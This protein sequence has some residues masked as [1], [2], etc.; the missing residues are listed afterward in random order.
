[1][2][3]WILAGAAAVALIGA[4][5]Y[6]QGARSLAEDAAAFGAREAVSAARLSPDGSRVLYVTPGPGLKS[7]AVISDLQTGKSSV[8]TSASG[9]PETLDW[10]NY[11][12]PA[13]LVCRISGQVMQTGDIV[14]FQ[15]LL[16]MNIDGTDA[17]LLGQPSSFYDASL[18][19]FDGSVLD[20]NG[21][22][23]GA[24][25]MERDYVPEAG[26][27]Q[28]RISRT[29]SGLGVDRID[30]RTLRVVQVEPA[31]DAASG[32]MTDGRGNIRVMTT[33]ETNSQGGLT[34]RVKYFYRTTDSREWKTLAEFVDREDQLRPL[35]VDAEINSIY[36]LKK[37]GGRRALYTIKLDGSMAERLIAE[38]PRVDINGVMR[39]GDGQRVIGYSFSD[40]QSERVYFDPE[41]KALSESL[42]RAM[43]DLPLVSFLDS[44]M[45]GRKLLLFAG[46]D[47]DPGR[48]Y[49]FDRDQQAL[50]EAMLDR[51]QLEGR[52]L[53]QVK[54]V[55]IP[56]PDGAQIPAYLTLPPG[57]DARNL[58]AIVLPH[59]GPSARDYW[60]FD[61]LSQFL[62]ARGYAVLQPQYRGS[63]GF[64]DAWLNENGFRNWR[65][66]IGDISAS[67]RWLSAQ[68]IANP[69]RVAIVGWSYGGYAALQS[70]ITDPS[71]YK[72]VVAIAPVTDL[73]MLK[74]DAQGFSNSRLVEK[75]IGSGP[76]VT[77]GSPL[78]RAAEIQAPVLL[79]HGD[80]DSNVRYWHS[81]KMR[82][83]LRSAGKQVE[84]VG[85]SGYDH[86][87]ED[88]KVRAELL[89]KI[90]Q[91][92]ERTIGE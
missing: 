87:L 53:A 73:Q 60:G 67:A 62:A 74:Q 32:Y 43:P 22:V 28:S 92:L 83:A 36:V 91:L 54:S 24:V 71:L 11:S 10:C 34:G 81:E 41:F 65:T 75:F 82:D 57:R 37:N 13:R 84:F 38:H 86:Y 6:A 3:S 63:S 59:G 9:E 16:S 4:P 21:A 48:Y 89:T 45:D 29:K 52:I 80:M 1:V 12:G 90:A 31:R 15:R 72:A 40:Q 78:R 5:A 51:P 35:A 18:R 17:K 7:F 42:S 61:W 50:N 55:T 70:A 33:V 68:G 2:K 26:R 76:H 79:V 46:S 47:N 30:T 27:I 64:G 56:A 23:D 14:G 69:N 19:Q 8:V 58:P 39:S 20:W 44:T 88:S 66:S 25:L 49:L 85:Y 77:E